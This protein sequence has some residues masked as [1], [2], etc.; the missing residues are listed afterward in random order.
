VTDSI[1]SRATEINVI[2]QACIGACHGVPGMTVHAM[3]IKEEKAF[4]K[5]NG[6][7][8]KGTFSTGGAVIGGLACVESGT[9][10]GLS[11]T[12]ALDSLRQITAAVTGEDPV[13]TGLRNAGV[14]RTNAQ[15][16]AGALDLTIGVI[17]INRFYQ[18]LLN[19][20][21]LPSA[22]GFSG[23]TAAGIAVAGFDTVSTVNTVDSIHDALEP[24]Q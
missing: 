20:A 9:T 6:R 23:G 1:F 4:R 19:S 5:F 15:S 12:L 18:G 10:C 13:I 24:N 14:S 21:A 22:T 16:A 8:V 7:L 11:V 2:Q 3:T 17:S